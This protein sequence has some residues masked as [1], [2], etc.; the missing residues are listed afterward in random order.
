[1]RQ[2]N[3]S[4]AVQ[5]DFL[6]VALDNERLSQAR[7][8]WLRMNALIWT[9]VATCLCVLAGLWVVNEI[10]YWTLRKEIQRKQLAPSNAILMATRAQEQ[11]QLIRYQWVKKSD[12]ILRIPLERAR[13]LVVAD[14]A[15]A[16]LAASAASAPVLSKDANAAGGTGP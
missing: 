12:G 10:F 7:V 2:T 3:E 1:M 14:Y 13:G 9:G 6:D 16:A 15:R 4:A 5:E 8:S 11:N